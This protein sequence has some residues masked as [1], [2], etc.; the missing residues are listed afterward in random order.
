V[1][2]EYG[3]T[4][5]KMAM[6]AAAGVVYYIKQAGLNPNTPCADA[7]KQIWQNETSKWQ[8]QLAELT[9]TAWQKM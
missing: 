7:L 5:E 6:G 2:L 3:V 9:Q 1:C 4:P 8:A